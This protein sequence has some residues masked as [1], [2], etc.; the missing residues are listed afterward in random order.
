MTKLCSECLE[1]KEKAAFNENQWL[2]PSGRGRCLECCDGRDDDDLLTG[3]MRNCG[4][5]PVTVTVT[6]PGGQTVLV[7]E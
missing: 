4:L 6:G 3:L 1:E 7:S 5:T 2:V